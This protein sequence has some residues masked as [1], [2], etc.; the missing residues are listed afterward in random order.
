[1]CPACTSNLA[2]DVG[3]HGQRQAEHVEGVE[4][5]GV[6]AAR[7]ALHL[8][9]ELAQE[10]VRDDGGV[11]L[12]VLRP[13][14]GRHLPVGAARGVGGGRRGARRGRAVEVLVQRV[15]QPGQ[16]LLR[17]VLA[18]ARQRARPA[19]HAPAHA[20]RGHR[21]RRARPHLPGHKHTQCLV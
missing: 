16:Q 5:H 21:P 14:L 11:A 15:Q 17:V 7:V 12:R 18:A 2:A 13:G 20:Q 4:A 3:L 8:G 1:M 19:L 6:P 10:Q 9:L